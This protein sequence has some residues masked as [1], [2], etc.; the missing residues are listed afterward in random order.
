MRM[1]SYL[2]RKKRSSKN[3]QKLIQMN[4]RR[5]IR[6]SWPKLKRRRRSLKM[7]IISKGKRKS[8]RLHL[9]RKLICLNRGKGR[10]WRIGFM[11]WH[12]RLR[13][14]MRWWLRQSS[15][16]LSLIWCLQ[17]H[18]LARKRTRI[19]YNIFRKQQRMW[20]GQRLL[21]SRIRDWNTINSLSH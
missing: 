15:M 11:M 4:S 9:S 17:S 21:K 3:R 13:R 20:R 16:S 6:E 14:S 19:W 18:H 7:S 10:E 5:I 1:R 2:N 8:R 12:S